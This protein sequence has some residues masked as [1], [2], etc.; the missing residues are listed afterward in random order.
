MTPPAPGL[1]AVVERVRGFVDEYLTEFHLL[2]HDTIAE[3]ED[4]RLLA[5]DLRALL[6]AVTW[7]EIKDAPKDGTPILVSNYGSSEDLLVRSVHWR[8]CIGLINGEPGEW[9][10]APWDECGFDWPTHFLPLPPSPEAA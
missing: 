9:I 8:P 1:S 7:R 5:S 3:M 2:K 4:A 6:S 10:H